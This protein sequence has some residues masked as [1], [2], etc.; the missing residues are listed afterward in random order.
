MKDDDD[1][2]IDIDRLVDQIEADD[3]FMDDLGACSKCGADEYD[4]VDLDEFFNIVKCSNCPGYYE[5][6]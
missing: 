1:L 4:F 6:H 3:A 5:H 2:D